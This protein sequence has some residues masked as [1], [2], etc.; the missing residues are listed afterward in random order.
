M[1]TAALDTNVLAS[2]LLRRGG[3]PDTILRNWRRRAFQLVLS[4][5]ILTELARTLEQPYFQSRLPEG[6]G[7]RDVTLLRQTARVAPLTSQVT[8]V[9]THS[10]DD[11]VLATALSGQ[12]TYL[13]T[14][15]TQLQRLGTHEGITI[16]SPRAFLHV[17]TNPPQPEEEQ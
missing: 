9:A 11:L 14:G 16:L 10:E 12:A 1:I 15:N 13:V 17:L 6:Q 5:H 8:G 3:I 4:E 7:E 2:A